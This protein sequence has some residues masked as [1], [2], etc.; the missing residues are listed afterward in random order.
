MKKI[1]NYCDTGLNTLQDAIE[2]PQDLSEIF[3]DL[4][5]ELFDEFY[6]NDVIYIIYD[7]IR[8]FTKS[9]VP[10]KR[11]CFITTHIIFVI[12]ILK[13]IARFNIMLCYVA[14]IAWDIYKR[15]Y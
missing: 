3:K 7:I 9:I 12:L 15:K 11:L 2:E 8:Y 13:A 10:L 6:L 14:H 5:E 4:Q 1:V